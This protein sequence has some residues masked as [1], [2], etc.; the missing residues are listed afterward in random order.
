[1]KTY[2]VI[3]PRFGRMQEATVA[4]WLKRVG[5]RVEEEEPLFTFETD[6]A[7]QEVKSEAA[8]KL[9]EIRVAAGNMA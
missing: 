5:E 9:V 2:E 3:L 6:K 7:N 4:E 8:G 1:M